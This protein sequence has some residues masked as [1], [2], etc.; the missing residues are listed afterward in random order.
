MIRQPISLRLR[1]IVTLTSLTIGLLGYEIV[2]Y[3]AHLLNPSTTTMPYLSEVAKGFLKI[4][5]PD[6]YGQIWLLNDVMATITRLIVGMVVSCTISIILGILM[7]CFE[8]VEAAFK[9]YPT[10]ASMIPATAMMAVFFLL[11]GTNF[12]FYVSILTF[13]VLPIL[14]LSIYNMT[15]FDVPNE[16][17]DKAYTLGA[18]N[19]EVVYEVVVP[20]LLPRILDMI[21]LMFGPAMLVLIAGEYQLADVGVGYR[22]R[23]QMRSLDMAVIYDYVIVLC[24]I[25]FFNNYVMIQLRRWWC[26]WYSE[27]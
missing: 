1:A 6:R 18:S 4:G 8:V 14:S 11:V 3:K 25:G 10:T 16:L 27:N 19:S 23:M 12:P 15:K 9:P 5:L 22:M 2:A 17:I 7:G 13:G 24:I 20:M 21:R 26:P